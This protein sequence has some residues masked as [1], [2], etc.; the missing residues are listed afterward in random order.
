[1][2]ADSDRYIQL[3]QVY[4]EQADRDDAIVTQKVQL[5]RC[6]F[7]INRCFT[8]ERIYTRHDCRLGQIYPVTAGLQRTSRQRW[9]N[10]HTESSWPVTEHRQGEFELFTCWVIIHTF[11]TG[12][13]STI[14]SETDCR[15]RAREF[16][17][18]L[19]RL[20]K[21]LNIQDCPEKSMKIKF[22][23]KSTWKTLKGFEKSMDFTISRRIQHS[24]WRPRSV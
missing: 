5:T 6:L 23:L 14:R 7:D 11:L 15:S 1:M 9:C 20:E 22:A 13:R 16:D 12:H 8:S 10:S 19:H 18:G 17:P 21:Y 4:R 3:Q 2:T 24:F